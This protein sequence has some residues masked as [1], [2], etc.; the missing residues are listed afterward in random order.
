MSRIQTFGEVAK[1]RQTLLRQTLLNAMTLGRV[2]REFGCRDDFKYAGATHYVADVLIEWARTVGEELH[3]ES[4]IFSEPEQL[5][6][7]H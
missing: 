4:D 2:M 3:E 1:L 6:K 7:P 5:L